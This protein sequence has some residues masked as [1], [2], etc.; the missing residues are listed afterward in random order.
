VT[1]LQHLELVRTYNTN[2][3][4]HAVSCTISV[5]ENEW[6][7]VGGW[8]FDHFDDICGLSFL[9][10]FEGDS[11]YTQMPYETIGAKDYAAMLA[12]MPEHIDWSDL[13]FY[14]KGID[15]VTGTREFA[16]VGNTCEI[17]ESTES[18]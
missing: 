14:E 12:R 11:S 8:V 6:P 7:S 16:C 13:A 3:S 4:E 15:T 18:L 10:H 2:W 5:K 1:A 17:V 9:P